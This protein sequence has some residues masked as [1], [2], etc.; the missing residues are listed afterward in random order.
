MVS[1]GLFVNGLDPTLQLNVASRKDH[2][3]LVRRR[4]DM[5]HV[6]SCRGDL[7]VTPGDD[8][9]MWSHAMWSDVASCNVALTAARAALCI[10]RVIR[11]TRFQLTT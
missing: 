7:V 4:R 11:M 6:S 3:Y 5:L 8:T 2:S 10:N 9:A 1:R